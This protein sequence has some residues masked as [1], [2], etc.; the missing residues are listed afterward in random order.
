MPNLLMQGREVRL[1]AE[2]TFGRGITRPEDEVVTYGQYVA[3]LREKMQHAHDLAREHLGKAAQRQKEVYDSRCSF[4]V[5]KSGD[6][7]WWETQHAQL[8]VAPKLR[9]PYDGPFLVLRR[10]NDLTYV[11]Q[12]DKHG[13]QRVVHCNKLRPYQGKASLSWARSALKKNQSL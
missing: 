3:K 6:L 4:Q 2:L 8:D 11:L 13:T 7:V 9:N 12:L 10:L 5:Y 1:P